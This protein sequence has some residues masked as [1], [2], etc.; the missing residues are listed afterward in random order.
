MPTF[1]SWSWDA[2]LP[3]PT[4]S[5]LVEVTRAWTRAARLRYA[6]VARGGHVSPST[7]SAIVRGTRRRPTLR[8]LRAIADGVAADPRTHE[9]DLEIVKQ[10]CRDLCT[11][12]AVASGEFSP[13]GP[14][15]PARAVPASSRQMGGR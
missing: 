15:Y 4:T 7:L 12:A 9:R 11:D 5:S 2:A 3:D 1:P 14:P 6:D 8:T 13:C 10:A